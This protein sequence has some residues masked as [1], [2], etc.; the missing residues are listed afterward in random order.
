MRAVSRCDSRVTAAD[1]I[2][3]GRALYLRAQKLMLLSKSVEIRQSKTTS[4]PTIRRSR[5]CIFTQPR[6]KAEIQ[7]KTLHVTH[8]PFR[9]GDVVLHE[10]T[11]SIINLDLR[12]RA[13]STGVSR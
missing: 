3:R 8:N 9:V 2:R 13:M 12:F 7:T 4:R 11:P 5:I 1:T 6:S 10:S